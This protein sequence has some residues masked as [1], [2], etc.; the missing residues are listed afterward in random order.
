MRPNPDRLKPTALPP[1]RSREPL[2]RSQMMSRIRARNTKPELL[3][4][5]AVHRLGL[6]FRNHGKDLPGN[7]DL[8][9][10]RRR[11]VIFVHGC[12]WHSHAG[13][14]LASQPKSNAGYWEPKLEGNLTR[15]RAHCREL[16]RRGYRVFVIWECETRRPEV[17]SSSVMALRDQILID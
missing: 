11:W 10:R 9:N 8:V 4:R 6:R 15:D 3:V 2:T 1:R 16:E 7:P 12:F 5:S 17:L 14:P 13:C